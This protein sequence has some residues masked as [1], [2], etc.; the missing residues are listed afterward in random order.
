MVATTRHI[1]S[2]QV[3]NRHIEI[4]RRDH[5]SKRLKAIPKHERDLRSMLLKVR[6]RLPGY[7]GHPCGHGPERVTRGKRYLRIGHE[8]VRR[9]PAAGCTARTAEMI[10]RD[11][12]PAFQLRM[13]PNGLNHRIQPVLV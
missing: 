9:D 6:G 5:K 2:A 13:L 12:E 8:S 3:R 1:A 4:E 7:R 10:P 11:Y